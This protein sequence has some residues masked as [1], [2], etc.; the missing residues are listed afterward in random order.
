MKE[1]QVLT[2]D[3]LTTIFS[4]RSIRL[5]TTKSVSREM[6]VEILKAAMSAPSAGNE[7]PWH[8]IVLTDRAI[9]DAIPKFHP[10][11]AMLKQA[12]VAILVCGDMTLEKH[13][14]YWTL[15]CAA[16]TENILLAA[17]AKGLG[18]VWCGV[19]PT[20]ERVA[21]L[22]KL[23]NLPGHI[24]PFSLIPLGFPAEEKQTQDRFD[25]SRVHENRW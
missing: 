17:H 20:K 21:N 2:M 23:L 14:G 4:R 19:Y 24:V 22:K 18:A 3:A 25:G 16:A 6:V 13:E 9:L 12:H 11:S 10:Y 1:R 15:D 5:Y 7:R 8:F